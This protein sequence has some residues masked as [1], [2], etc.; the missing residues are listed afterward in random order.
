MTKLTPKQV[1]EVQKVLSTLQRKYGCDM[2]VMA[3][4]RQDTVEYFRQAEVGFWEGVAKYLLKC[5]NCGIDSLN[6]QMKNRA[7]QT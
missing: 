6:D 2:V 1:A 5:L 4:H 7:A 3:F